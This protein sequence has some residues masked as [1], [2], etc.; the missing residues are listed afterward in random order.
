MYSGKLKDVLCRY[1]VL[2]QRKSSHADPATKQLGHLVTKSLSD[3]FLKRATV[4]FKAHEQTQHHQY[5]RTQVNEFVTRHINLNFD[6][7]SLLNVADQHQ[8]NEYKKILFSIVKYIVFLAA[9]NLT[10]H[11]YSDDG[12]PCDTNMHQ[13]NFKNQI[14]FRAEAGDIILTNHLQTCARNAS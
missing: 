3:T 14:A 8:Q 4:T 12:L 5:S 13:G 2:F 7:D 11:G 9:N 10:L 6:V 1:C